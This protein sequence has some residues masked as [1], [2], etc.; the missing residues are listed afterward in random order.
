MNAKKVIP[1]LEYKKGITYSP[2]FGSLVETPGPL[3]REYISLLYLSHR[4]I[5]S[6]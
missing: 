3:S 2:A 4:V 5:L 1:H 6:K